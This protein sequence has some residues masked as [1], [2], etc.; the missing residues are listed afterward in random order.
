LAIETIYHASWEYGFFKMF[1]QRPSLDHIE[2][3]QR[4][5]MRPIL[6]SLVKVRKQ[7]ESALRELECVCPEMVREYESLITGVR[8]F[9]TNK[10]DINFS[11]LDTFGL[12]YIGVPYTEH[13]DLQE[14][15][16]EAL[17]HEV[18][19]ARLHV[20]MMSEPMVENESHEQFSFPTR[21]DK[22]SMQAVFHTPFVY[23]RILMMLERLI[24]KH[25]GHGYLARR[26]EEI[27]RRY[28]RAYKEVARGAR[29]TPVGAYFLRELRSLHS[30]G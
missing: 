5:K 23:A 30:V 14:S 27:Q 26:Y 22:Q 12:I 10:R 11:T 20:M 3:R 1:S 7:V 29:L 21:K 24:T 28:S 8:V 19:H 15:L 6:G 18:A 17:V 9:H 4:P 13:P 25:P 2:A 16:I